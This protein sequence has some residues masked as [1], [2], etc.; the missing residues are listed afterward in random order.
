L[1]VYKT[2][3]KYF[4]NLN[5]DLIAA[6]PG[7]SMADF[8]RGLAQAAK[9]RPQHL[10]VYGLMVEEGT[11]LFSSGFAADDNLCRQ[12]LEHAAAYLAARGYAQYEISNFALRG[13]ESLHNIN[14]WRGGEYLGLGAAA[15]SYIKG[16]RRCNTKDL[17]IYINSKTPPCESEVLKGKA[18][19][20]EQ[21]ILGLRMTAGIN[22]TAPQQRAFAADIKKLA[23]RGLLETSG[24]NIRLTDEGKYMAN[25]VWRHFVEPF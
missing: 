24:K 21:I 13:R 25:E 20:G 17:D 2:A 10:S 15:A 23:A 22:L 9:L 5:I 4:D 3:Q 12:M 16:V 1:Q 7:Q 11:K 14:Y 8:T 19:L 6:L 18:K